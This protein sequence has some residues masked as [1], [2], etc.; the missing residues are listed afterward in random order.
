MDFSP[1]L[2][3]SPEQFLFSATSVWSQWKK[4][5]DYKTQDFLEVYESKHTRKKPM[6]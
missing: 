1:F 6:S 5:E 4:E 2:L 3:L